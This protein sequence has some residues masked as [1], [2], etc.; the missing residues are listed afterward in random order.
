MRNARS[1]NLLNSIIDKTIP[2]YG[3]MI[4]GREHGRFTEHA[5]AYDVKGRV[6]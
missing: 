2:M 6:S 4:H 1:P 3:R 5:Q